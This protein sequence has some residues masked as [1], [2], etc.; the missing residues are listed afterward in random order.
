MGSPTSNWSVSSTPLYAR[1]DDST[2]FELQIDEGITSVIEACLRLT[3]TKGFSS[4]KGTSEGKPDA[5]LVQPRNVVIEYVIWNSDVAGH[6]NR[7]D[8]FPAYHQENQLLVVFAPPDVT[9]PLPI[10][11]SKITPFPAARVA[12]VRF[13]KSTVWS[14]Q[15]EFCLASEQPKAFPEPVT[16]NKKMQVAA[17]GIPF[18]YTHDLTWTIYKGG[19]ELPVDFV[20]RHVILDEVKKSFG[21]QPAQT[22]VV[23]AKRRNGALF[24]KIRLSDGTFV[25][26]DVS[27]ALELNGFPFTVDG[28][29]KAVKKVL[30]ENFKGETFNIFTMLVYP[31][32]AKQGDRAFGPA[33]DIGGVDTPLRS[34]PLKEPYWVEV[35]QESAEKQ[36]RRKGKVV[37]VFCSGPRDK[38]K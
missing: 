36:R 37:G 11:R 17:D 25:A 23:E 20:A 3:A 30:E 29:K 9:V 4:T 32:G 22:V 31:A 34:A 1:G 33:S 16:H 6:F 24:V 27:N 14:F 5:V 8:L 19:P 10:R 21:F 12:I 7:F 2:T 35:T 38:R 18:E 28:L 26:T 13:Y 15:L